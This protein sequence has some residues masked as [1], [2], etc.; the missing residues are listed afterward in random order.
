M[1]AVDPKKLVISLLGLAKDIALIAGGD[2][3]AIVNSID[4]LR[5]AVDAVAPALPA[6][7]APDLMPTDRAAADA[8]AS[9]DEDTKFPK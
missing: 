3:A 8:S 4:D 1:S 7:Y 6:V 5:A 9:H 2:Y